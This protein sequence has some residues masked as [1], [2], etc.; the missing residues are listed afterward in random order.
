MSI[1]S[2]PKR[3]IPAVKKEKDGTESDFELLLDKIEK[4]T[5]RIEHIENLLR[6]KL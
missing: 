2:Y 6:P 4:H 3:F 1:I 5:E